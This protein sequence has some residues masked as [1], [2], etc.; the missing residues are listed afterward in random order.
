MPLIPFRGLGSL[1]IIK[2]LPPTDIPLGAFT[3]GNNVR[4]SNG[5]SMRAPGW[6]TGSPDIGFSPSGTFRY[7]VPGGAE[8]TFI[9]GPYG[10]IRVRNSAGAITDAHPAAPLVL[11]ASQFTGCSLGSVF[12]LNRETHVPRYWGPASSTFASIPGWTSTDRC[13]V[14]RSFKDFLVAFNVTKN[15]TPNPNLVKWSDAA[16]AGAPPAS[17]DHTDPT[18]LA[19]ETPLAEINGPIVDAMNLRDAM[20][21][22]GQREV[23]LMEY[24]G[25]QFIFRFRRLFNDGGI[26][27]RNCAIEI[28]GKHFVFGVDDIYVHD[29]VSRQSIAEGRVRDFV[30]RNIDISKVD[31]CFVAHNVAS[32]EILFCYYSGDGDAQFGGGE[33]VNR[34][35]VYCYTNDTWGIMD[36]P[37]VFGPMSLAP[38]IGGLTY[39][40]VTSDYASTGGSYQNSS[41]SL[42]LLPLA[43]VRLLTG[44]IASNRISLLDN[45]DRGSLSSFPLDTSI[46]TP[47]YLEKEH[48]DLDDSGSDLTTYKTI[49]GVVPQ[50]RIRTDIPIKFTFG[51]NDLHG[52][53]PEWEAPVDYYPRQDYRVD[54]R[55]SGRYLA[56]RVDVP[57]PDDFSLTGFDAYV[58]SNG[59]R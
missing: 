31:R 53:S 35:V 55:M 2:D 58:S 20:I 9:P 30:F 10:A 18:K 36:M 57:T 34:A 3:G 28:E 12:Y 45:I 33:G 26:L 51:A 48:I 46:L 8:L 50:V 43:A 6:R 17:W 41:G 14:L 1:G 7:T 25:N 23:W 39:D 37:N 22:Y 29:G 44:R 32:K 47:A 21:I 27:N 52:L 38:A 54:T 56:L 15:G 24:V 40:T 42:R 5:A 13:E 59:N 16:L 11:A 4:F 49:Y 19:G